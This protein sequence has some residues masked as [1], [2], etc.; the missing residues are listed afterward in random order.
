MILTSQGRAFHNFGAAA[1]NA[2][3]PSV[4]EVLIMGG[5]RRNLSLDLGLYL[6]LGL[7][8]TKSDIYLAAVP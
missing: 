7:K 5:D 3:S 2:L 6:E 8:V 1:I 4:G